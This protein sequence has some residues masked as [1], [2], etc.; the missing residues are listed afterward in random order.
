MAAIAENLKTSFIARAGSGVIY[1]HYAQ[2]APEVELGGDF[3][4]MT[5]MKE[6]FDPE[7]LLNR[8]RLY[9]RI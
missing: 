1:A 9:G 3:A 6:M 7:R 2:D 8:G 4:M 5:K